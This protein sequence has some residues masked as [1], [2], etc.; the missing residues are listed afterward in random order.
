MAQAG[1]WE[2]SRQEMNRESRHVGAD[3]RVCPIP[4]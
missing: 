1:M 4:D 3:P 2:N